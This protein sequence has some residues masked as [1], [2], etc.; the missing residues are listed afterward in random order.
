MCLLLI[1]KSAAFGQYQQPIFDWRVFLAE[2]GGL[3]AWTVLAQPLKQFVDKSPTERVVS[4][5]ILLG[6]LLNQTTKGV[7]F[8]TWYLGSW[9]WW[10]HRTS[11][12]LR[13]GG[14]EMASG[15]KG[16]SCTC[17]D[18]CNAC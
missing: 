18:N 8:L 6:C 15:R 7:S 2:S 16:H 5:Q 1:S 12:A 11:C 13:S 14:I 3:Q 4:V 10:D 17:R 9:L